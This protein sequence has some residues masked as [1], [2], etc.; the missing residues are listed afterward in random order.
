MSGP[1]SGRYNIVPSFLLQPSPGVGVPFF[2]GGTMRYVAFDENFQVAM[3]CGPIRA[4]KVQDHV[5]NGRAWSITP[6]EGDRYVIEED[7]P[8][9][10]R[11]AWTLPSPEPKSKVTLQYAEIPLPN[12][13]WLFRPVLED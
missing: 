2:V 9:M 10:P 13:Q 4:R 7:I 5:G 8:I 11:L 6:L 3:E 12:Q 1:A